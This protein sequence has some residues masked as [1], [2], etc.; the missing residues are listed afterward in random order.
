MK[1]S[2]V[3]PAFNASSTI[4]ETVKAICNPIY[5]FIDEVII[6]NDGSTDNTLSII[7]KLKSK[8]LKIKYFSSTKNK[9]GG[10]A[11]NFGIK[12]C[13]NQLIMVLDADELIHETSLQKIY[14]HALKNNHTAHYETA[15]YFSEIY[16]KTDS[17]LNYYKVYGKNITYN[18]FIKNH[19]S[20]V[21]FIFTKKDWIKA[22]KYS[23]ITH[24]D[25]QD[26]STKFLKKIGTIKIIKGTFYYHRRFVK[27][28]LSYYERQELSG[29]NFFNSYKLFE[30]IVE[31]LNLKNL[32][33][34]LRRNVFSSINIDS[35]L[36]NYK[37]ELY[38]EFFLKSKL[39]Q[40]LI[41]IIILHK[42]KKFRK[43]KSLLKNYLI[44][45]KSYITDLIL[46][47]I[48]RCDQ[49]FSNKEYSEFRK[50][51]NFFYFI[52]I[53]KSYPNSVK[54]IS[55]YFKFVIYLI[56]KKIKKILLNN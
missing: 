19:I 2:V 12:K 52:N 32:V 35:A 9:G 6:Y 50:V 25:T 29:N 48:I 44:N 54:L 23:T 37:N 31:D 34:L 51:K 11:R 45:E 3:I 4:E 39:L 8:F 15:K 13:K 41:Q 43:A 10:F 18:K 28:N 47:L 26:Y 24:W 36:Q 16:N 17:H 42:N 38:P 53:F 49:T 20:P 27:N 1:L 40:S 56:L 22:G 21:N 55:L 33:F 30:L 46:F 14:K 5:Y 7:K